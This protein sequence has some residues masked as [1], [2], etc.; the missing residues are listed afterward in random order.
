MKY[1]IKLFFLS[2]IFSFEVYFLTAQNDN[3]IPRQ[4]SI[5]I[6]N[7]LFDLNNKQEL[8]IPFFNYNL[9]F[10]VYDYLSLYNLSIYNGNAGSFNI[11]F[12]Y[13]SLISDNYYN[14][15]PFYNHVLNDAE[16][17]IPATADT[18]AT[19]AFYSSGK[20]KE[21]HF[22]IFHSQK[23]DSLLSLT[24]N[25]NIVNS[26][27][28]YLNQ[29]TNQ[30]HFYG[31]LIYRARNYRYF[32]TGGFISNKIQQKENGGILFTEQFEDTVQYDR[33]FT[34]VNFNFA[35]RLYKN[36]C[37]FLNQY[38]KIF[39]LGSK[40]QIIIGYKSNIKTQY[41]VF[42]DSDPMNEKYPQIL[43]DSTQTYD[44]TY[45]MLFT[46]E[47]SISNYSPFDTVK[48]NHYYCFSYNFQT[49]NLKQLYINDALYRNAVRTVASM[50]IYKSMKFFL[51]FNYFF[52][53]YNNQNYRGYLQLE[54]EFSSRHIKSAGIRF[55]TGSLNPG[56]INYRYFSNHFMW[57]NEFTA[58]K[59]NSLT[60][61]IST[62]SAVINFRYLTIK[63]YVHLNEYAVPQQYN[64]TY[65]LFNAYTH[66][67][68][69]WGKFYFENIIGINL[70]NDKEAPMRLP[71]FYTNIKTGVEFAIF[72]NKLNTFFGIEN[73]YFSEFY[74]DTWSVPLSMFYIQNHT[75][76][77]NFMYPGL[78]LGLNLKR[79][80]IFAMI[81]NVSAGMLKINY[82]AMPAYPRYDR[83]FRW[84]VSWSFMN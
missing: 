22:N 31:Y 30:N 62:K 12:Y 52:G 34:A 4:D 9:P 28:L 20:N 41:N 80:R 83:F 21:Q 6:S 11:P 76:I 25:Y 73:S 67:K 10:F 72:N 64:N 36:R 19:N 8:N 39:P 59:E 53:E 79:A 3:N 35:E 70:T 23:I 2:S 84:G 15:L 63:D 57:D 5:N 65:S 78:F 42:S 50:R 82:Y 56:F 45:V 38:Y 46:N 58:Q 74:A 27:G 51:D 71:G 16:S 18:N 66:V 75:K 37:L 29:K 32:A 55:N 81:E 14:L 24:I 7:V 33:Q 49:A 48:K 61:F 43:I 54:K 17:I 47:I 60:C 69:Y 44:S 26:P 68:T 1:I 40:R 13:T 77:G